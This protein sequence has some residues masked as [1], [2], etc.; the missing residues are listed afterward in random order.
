MEQKSTPAGIWIVSYSYVDAMGTLHTAE[1]QII[2]YSKRNA[3]SIVQQYLSECNYLEHKITD[4]KL[5][6]KIMVI[7]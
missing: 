7:G 4:V 2:G 5:F 1:D 6:D 3:A